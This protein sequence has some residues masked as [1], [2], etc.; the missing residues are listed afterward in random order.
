MNKTS[1]AEK[2]TAR[3]GLVLYFGVL[4]IGSAALESQILQTGESI[5]KVQGLILALMY[6]PAVASFVARLVLKEGFADISL[7]FGGRAGRNA[8]FLGWVFPM[9][10]GF[11]S[12]GIAW[13]TGVAQF[14]SPLSTSSHLYADSATL[15]LAASFLVS[16]TYGAV[17]NCIGGFGE[18]VGWR[19]Y[20]L[21][22]LITAGVPKPVFTSGLIW[23]FWHL[24][25]VVTGQYAG[26]SQPWLSALLFLVAVVPLA[27]LM[28]YLRLQSGS[29]WPA[30]IAHG[31]WNSIIQG[32]FDRA[33]R[34]MP[35]AVGEA[36]W[37]TTTVSIIIV[38]FLT[39]GA[40][41]LQRR[42]KERF[43]L[44]SGRPAS[45]LTV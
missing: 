26:G 39:R 29:V 32:T 3:R 36:G 30:V 13:A 19:G 31:A 15:N 44:P 8:A 27:Y 10:V 5:G 23:G 7:R 45:I 28:A 40:W 38:V 17:M 22:R 43:V 9:A 1:E 2:K 41:T 37:I 34:G 20:M 6:V 25:F 33:T 18:E 42:P 35:S 21:T 4:I 24:P 11:V 14:E 12:Y 16:A